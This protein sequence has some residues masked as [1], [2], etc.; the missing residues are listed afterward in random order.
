MAVDKDNK[1]VSRRRPEERPASLS[2]PLP[3]EKLPTDLQK[4]VDREDEF[5]DMLYDGQYD[6]TSSYY[7]EWKLLICE[8]IEPRTRPTPTFDMPPMRIEY[9]Q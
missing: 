9:G 2:E 6:S 3:R 8:M 1:I 5:L 7:D 4:L